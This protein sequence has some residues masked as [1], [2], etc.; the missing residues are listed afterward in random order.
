MFLLEVVMLLYGGSR[1][2]ARYTP[3]QV[4]DEKACRIFTK[5]CPGAYYYVLCTF[6]LHTLRLKWDVFDFYCLTPPFRRLVYYTSYSY[7]EN[8][9]E[10]SA[11]ISF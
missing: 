1:P 11:F 10:N 5:L 7:C 8:E 2:C 9:N 3:P 4:R 6:V